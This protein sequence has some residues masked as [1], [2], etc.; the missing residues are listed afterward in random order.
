MLFEVLKYDVFRDCSVG[1]R[2]IP[3]PPEPLA[4]VA[5]LELREFALHFVRRSAFH[6]PNQV[7]HCK[8]GW[9]RDEHMNMICR[10]YPAD[11]ID[12]LL[13][14]DLTADV[15]DTQSDI[16]NQYFVAVLRRP[17]QMIAMVENAMAAGGILHVDT[18]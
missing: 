16:T 13:M 10:Q 11:D 14:T 3:A 17:H 8:F 7:T 9:N 15:A 4:P 1:G 12:A 5:L 6:E 2:E 18:L